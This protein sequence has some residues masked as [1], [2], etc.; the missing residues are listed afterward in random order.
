[1]V[2]SPDTLLLDVP[3]ADLDQ[4]AAHAVRKPLTCG[5]CGQPS[6]AFATCA[7]CFLAADA[8]YTR[9]QDT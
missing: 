6:G 4:V 2:T 1:M 9:G 7:R 8:E 5:E 3:V